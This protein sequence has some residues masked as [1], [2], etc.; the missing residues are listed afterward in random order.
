MNTYDHDRPCPK[1]GQKD[2]GNHYYT[3]GE[4]YRMF[5]DCLRPKEYASEDIIHRTCRN[6]SFYWNELPYK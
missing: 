5:V 4:E 6:C 3:K 2:I 1:C